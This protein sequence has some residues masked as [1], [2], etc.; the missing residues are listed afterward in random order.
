MILEDLVAATQTRIA[1]EKRQVPL[2]VLKSQAEALS[3]VPAI[4]FAQH[5]HTPGLHIIGELKQASPSR[6]ES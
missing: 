1:A 4:D 3:A 2:Q 6:G 5:L